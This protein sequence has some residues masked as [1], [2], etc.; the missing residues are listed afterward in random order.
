MSGMAIR[1]RTHNSTSV[2]QQAHT[3]HLVGDEKGNALGF[4]LA[5]DAGSRVIRGGAW[6]N[7]SDPQDSLR[8]MSG[9]TG[10]GSTVGFRLCADGRN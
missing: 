9:G 7:N 8:T 4:R 5:H 3:A 6:L 10:F 1:G 2:L